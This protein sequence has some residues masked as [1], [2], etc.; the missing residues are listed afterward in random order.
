MNDT[1]GPVSLLPYLEA[2]TAARL[3][4]TVSVDEKD[5]SAHPNRLFPFLVAS[6][7]GPFS[8]LIAANIQTDGGTNIESVFLLTQKDEYALTTDDLWPI[9]NRVIGQ[10]WQRAFSFHSRENSNTPPLVLKD[11]ISENGTLI[12]FQA[13]LYCKFKRVYFHPL[14]P[15]CSATLQQCFDDSLLNEYG[16]QPYSNSL[17]RYLVCPSCVESKETPDFYVSSLTNDDPAFLKD[18]FVLIKEFGKL[19]GNGPLAGRFPCGDCNRYTECY[20]S[21]NLAVS[22]IF[23]FSF[24]PFYMLILKA[25]SINALDFLSLISGVS[26]EE[27]AHQLAANQQPARLKSLVALKGKEFT[28]TPFFFREENRY[29]L[30]VLYLKLSFL[31]ELAQAIFSGLDTF[32]RP[33][34]GLSVDRIWIKLSDQNSLLPAFW[35]FKLNL[36]DI[37]GTDP[38]SVSIPKLPQSYGLHFLGAVWF[39]TLLVNS[40]QDASQVNMG[41]GEAV[42]K[43][44]AETDVTVEQYLENSRPPVFSPEN[45]FWNPGIMSVNEAWNTFWEDSL[46]LGFQLFEGS[47]RD[48]KGWPKDEFV[49][50]LENLRQHIREAL[51]PPESS[52]PTTEHALENKAISSIL[53]KIMNQWRDGLQ[54][55]ADELEAPVM[56]METDDI[57]EDVPARSVQEDTDLDTCIILSP[58]GEVPEKSPAIEAVEELDE[59]VIMA[60]TLETPVEKADPVSQDNDS[61]DETIILSPDVSAT[62]SAPPAAPESAFTKTTTLTPEP[63]ITA[64]KA[65]VV[66]PKDDDLDETIIMGGAP[67]KP[68]EKADPVSQDNDSMDETIILSPD[69]ST[70]EAAPSAAPEDDLDETIIATPERPKTTDS[71]NKVPGKQDDLDETVILSPDTVKKD[72]ATPDKVPADENKKTETPDSDSDEFLDET[73]IVQTDKTGPGKA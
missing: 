20:G 56:S 22:R 40:K 32:Q 70:K 61:M 69:V 12:P 50:D 72:A 5:D 46:C 43:I 35:N 13:M 44:E 73:I 45:I 4:I 42:G 64:D 23:A 8:R 27:I 62:D 33:G 57:L 68:V 1:I 47:L 19:K 60:G 71:E 39:Y 10:Y 21:E 53:I 41:V 63:Q 55:P 26:Y 29:F 49:K 30:E 38:P 34:L 28:K 14:C 2:E 25:D 3:H 16:L 37:I 66:H 58:D 15:D 36:L 6:E 52:A 24:Y 17:K 59:T 31:G 67:E 51:F 9:D 54:V 7:S 18:R 48:L 65:D 11:Q